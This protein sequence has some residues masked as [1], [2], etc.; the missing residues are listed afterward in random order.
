MGTLWIGFLTDEFKWKHKPAAWSFGIIVLAL[1]MPTVLFFQYG[2]FYEYDYWAGTVSLVIFAL[3]ESILFAWA[4]GIKKG[5][6]EIT[7]NA[8]IKVPVIYKFI[9]KFVTPFFYYGFLLDHNDSQ[10]W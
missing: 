6:R 8:E 10:R 2:I 4:F 7:A 3:L 9:I 5:W 1:E